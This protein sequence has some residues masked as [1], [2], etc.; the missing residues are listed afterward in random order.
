[1][2]QHILDIVRRWL[3]SR[4]LVCQWCG[5]MVLQDDYERH[6]HVAGHAGHDLNSLPKRRSE[7]GSEGTRVL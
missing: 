1:M 6:W 4:F 2:R 7:S 5:C 3:W